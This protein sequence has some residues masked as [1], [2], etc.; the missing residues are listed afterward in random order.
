[1]DNSFQYWRICHIYLNHLEENNSI[2][3]LSAEM[4]GLSLKLFGILDPRIP[5]FRRSACFVFSKCWRP[6]SLLVRSASLF[7]FLLRFPFS[8]QTL[9]IYCGRNFNIFDE[10]KKYTSSQNHLKTFYFFP[11]L[12]IQASGALMIYESTVRSEFRSTWVENVCP[13]QVKD[14]KFY[15]YSYLQLGF[16]V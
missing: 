10:V 16:L 9:C 6:V 13:K 3:V 12:D 11:F 7:H 8:G 14:L 4:S 1:M 2:C 5:S 15:Y